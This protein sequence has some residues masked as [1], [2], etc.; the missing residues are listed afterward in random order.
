MTGKEKW[1]REE[2]EEEKRGRRERNAQGSKIKLDKIPE[3]N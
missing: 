2:K 3:E 1:S